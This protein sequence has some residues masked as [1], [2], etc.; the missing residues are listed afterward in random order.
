MRSAG[1]LRRLPK[2][3]VLADGESAGLLVIEIT[4]VGKDNDGWVFHPSMSDE[5]S[6]VVGHEMALTGALGVPDEAGAAATV[7][8]HSGHDA[9][10]KMD[11]VER[12]N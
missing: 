4:A 8:A 5:L 12:K 6:G 3:K 10:N 2:D 7:R 1:E 9:L 11:G